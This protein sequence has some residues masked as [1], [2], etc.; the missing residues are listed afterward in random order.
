[1]C[2]CVCVCV[3]EGS[4]E[5][6]QR[7]TSLGP[8]PSL[9][10]VF[11]V[12]VIFLAFLSLFLIEKPCFP[13]KKDNFCYQFFCVS[14][15]FSLAVFLAFPFF[16]FSLSLSFSFLSSLLTGSHLCFWFLLF[17]FVVFDPQTHDSYFCSS[18]RVC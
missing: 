10:F 11:F 5:V 2:V 14:F 15:C 1:M 6:A 13:P 18:P 17:V 4:G 8:K 3:C 7:A 9:F 16:T 12:C